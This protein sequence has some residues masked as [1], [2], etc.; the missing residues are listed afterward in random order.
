MVTKSKVKPVAAPAKTGKPSLNDLLGK[1]DKKAK[2]HEAVKIDK[3]PEIVLPED[4]AEQ[5][6]ILV[7]YSVIHG[8]VEARFKNKKDD[9]SSEVFKLWT[10]TVYDNKCCPSSN[11]KLSSKKA[12]RT[13]TGIFQVQNR[14]SVEMPEIQEGQAPEDVMID[15]LTSM[16]VDEEVAMQV[17]GDEL[18]FT[19]KRGVRD[20]NKVMQEEGGEDAVHRFLLMCFGK[21]EGKASTIEVEPLTDKDREMLFYLTS[22]VS[23][24]E[25]FLDRLPNIAKNLGEFRAIL[26]VI[27][28]VNFPSHM[29]LVTDDEN[30]TLASI[31]SEM[32][33]IA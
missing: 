21:A 13:C 32:L 24:A 29:K 22:S 1:L 11:P 7:G 3:R 2:P 20:L 31:A 27:R 26:K 28:P 9:V 19:P 18:D 12:D 16:G 10:Q 23:V 14:F 8:K 25:G 17:V 30:K 15:M 4:L 6:S 33:G 5:F